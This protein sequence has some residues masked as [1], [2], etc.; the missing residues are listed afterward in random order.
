M[1]KQL[2][3]AGLMEYR[4]NYDAV[5]RCVVEECVWKPMNQNPSKCS[6]NEL[7]RE[8][9]FLR[10]GNRLTYPADEVALQLR[11]DILVPVFCLA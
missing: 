8:W 3:V 10:Q 4:Y 7:E 5:F 11:R 1:L 6:M 9:P 2:W